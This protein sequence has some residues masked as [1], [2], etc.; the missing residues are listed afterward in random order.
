[1]NDRGD[2]ML[3]A[4]G[5]VFYP[6]DPHPD[7]VEI[8]DIA[9]ALGMA[10]RYGGHCKRFFSVAEHCV[11]MAECAPE[12]LKLATL[13]HDA[14]EAYLQDVIRPVKYSLPGYLPIEDR[15]M[16]VIASKY[17]FSWPMHPEI[18]VLDERMIGAERLQAVHP[19]AL[20]KTWSRWSEVPPLDVTIEFWSP[21]YAKH[22]FLTSFNTL[23]GYQR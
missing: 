3:T 12:P 21:D 13:M 19:N 11:K 4:S 1:M 22:A 9:H 20:K 15:L 17:G 18:K 6:L 10:C 2:W 5:G 16:R 8:Y 7:E 23:A 14:S